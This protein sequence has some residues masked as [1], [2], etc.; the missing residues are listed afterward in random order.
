MRTFILEN[1]EIILEAMTILSER[2][3]EAATLARIEGV[4]E[5][6]TDAPRLG[7]GDP[8]AP[9]RVI[10]FFD[11]KCVPCRAVHP[12]LV[13]FVAENP[14]VRVEM[15]HLPILTPGSEWGARFALATEAV[16]GPEAYSAVNES[17]WD[18]KGPLNTP[19]FE[20]ISAQLDLD[21][22]MIEAAMDSPEIDARIDFN[23]DT[24]IALEIF[25]TPAF[26]SPTSVTMGS[27]DVA[28]M[29]E[30]WLSQ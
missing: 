13:A 11:Y 3:A 1:P 10:E 21:Y 26:V 27:T 19:V 28:A 15:R 20:Q 14:D 9:R 8:N 18:A 16:Y 30:A 7:V 12:R 23:R 2:E 25:G 24:A 29:S 6:F 4:S 5:I 22:T 17:L